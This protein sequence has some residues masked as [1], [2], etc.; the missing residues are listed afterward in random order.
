MA[1][2]QPT[3]TPAPSHDCWVVA[4]D[5]VL[6]GCRIPAGFHTDLASIPRWA[7]WLVSP[8][9]PATVPAAVLHDFRYTTHNCSRLQ[10]DNEFYHMLR[11]NGVSIALSAVMWTAVRLGGVFYWRF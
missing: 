4:E 10:A 3:L 11:A 6:N 1:T 5:V 2:E 7:K 9:H 8:D